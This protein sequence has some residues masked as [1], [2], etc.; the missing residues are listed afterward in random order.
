MDLNFAGLAA[1]NAGSTSALQAA[2]FSWLAWL[3]AIASTVLVI[4]ATRTGNRLA[5]GICVLAGV[6]QLIV[7]VFA[8][9]GPLPW[10]VL[11]AGFGNTRLGTALVFL[12]F[13][14]LIATGVLVLKATEGP[15][16][17]QDQGASGVPT[18]V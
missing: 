13:F 16:A 11:I 18:T 2:Y 6:F 8:M 4:V 15:R 14:A 1:A 3:F 17:D 5:S 12:G 9:K 7:T 10:H